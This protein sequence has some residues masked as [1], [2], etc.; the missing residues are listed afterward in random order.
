MNEP[1]VVCAVC[2][3]PGVMKWTLSRGPEVVILDLCAEHEAPLI[4]FAKLG[5]TGP[6]GTGPTETQAP[7]RAA[8]PRSRF[9]PLDW[10]PPS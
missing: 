1:M 6:V 9:E 3:V 5:R 2:G 7:K 10:Q 4:E 8:R